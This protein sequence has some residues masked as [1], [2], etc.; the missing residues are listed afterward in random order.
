MDALGLRK[1]RPCGSSAGGR[2][3]GGVE[4]E[5]R[6]KGEKGRLI[7][8]RCERHEC[9]REKS[10]REKGKS[11]RLGAVSRGPGPEGANRRAN[12]VMPRRAAGRHQKG[13]GREA[14]RGRKEREA[15]E[16]RGMA[17][18]PLR[19]F[20]S[21]LLFSLLRRTRADHCTHCTHTTALHLPPQRLRLPPSL[22]L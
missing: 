17:E 13:S 11:R 12:G 16:E 1:T 6:E 14:A 18:I 4:A 10:E 9:D 2:A 19:L 7:D 21:L 5:K 15:K 8:R 20:V 3:G 22:P